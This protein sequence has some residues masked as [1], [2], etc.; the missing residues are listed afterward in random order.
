ML[1]NYKKI[2]IFFFYLTNLVVLINPELAYLIILI[3]LFSHLVFSRLKI[4][5]IKTYFRLTYLLFI[6]FITGFFFSISNGY[7]NILRDIFYFSTPIL[8][9]SFGYLLALRL[10][11]SDVFYHLIVC[12]ILVIIYQFVDFFF[13][14]GFNFQNNIEAFHSNNLFLISLALS[15]SLINVKQA[16][17][18]FKLY[19]K[20]IISTLL[21]L[22]LLLINQRAHYFTFFILILSNLSFFTI[23]N[24]L[25]FKKTFIS[26]TLILIS[27][28]ILFFNGDQINNKFSNSVKEITNTT[29]ENNRE[30][31]MYWRAFES[32]NALKLFK[33]SSTINK[34]FGYG[35]GKK[36]DLGGSFE[37]K[38]I[39]SNSILRLHNGY[40][41]V[42]IKTGI[43]GLTAIILFYLKII[44]ANIFVRRNDSEKKIFLKKII[45]GMSLTLIATTV[46]VSGLFNISGMFG[47]IIIFG[48][49]LKKS[50]LLDG[51][52]L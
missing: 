13:L 32:Y 30:V 52:V 18:H 43:L 35:F 29:F 46:I 33:Q 21:I 34:V 24:K 27:I 8:L 51:N 48:F 42:L 40:L 4:S 15:I 31:T 39:I 20:L 45:L 6:I 47:F 17:I 9:L 2:L 19:S 5:Y 49:L 38:D 3:F 22:S 1:I 28:S 44:K 16:N 37:L 14:K 12:S 23:Q 11:I 25:S 50:D 10:K 41:N 7:L 26:L 36:I